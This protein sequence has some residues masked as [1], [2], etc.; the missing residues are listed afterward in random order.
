MGH[1]SCYHWLGVT[2]QK[3]CR[4]SG[5]LLGLEINQTTI[6]KA[7][8]NTNGMVQID[9]GIHCAHEA[10]PNDNTHAHIVI[11]VMKP[12]TLPALKEGC[13]CEHDGS[14][15]GTARSITDSQRRTQQTESSQTCC[16]VAQLYTIYV[17]SA[18]IMTIQ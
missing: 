1:C 3:N 10:N 8:A 7:H 6:T 17:N 13:V 2:V 5:D 16:H 9:A 4:M 15:I 12:G 18:T 11:S 14:N